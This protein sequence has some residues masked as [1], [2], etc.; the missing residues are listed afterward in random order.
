[1]CGEKAFS[2]QELK[3]SIK[4]IV[5]FDAPMQKHTTFQIGGPARILVIP[6]DIGD[7]Q[8]SILYAKRHGLPIRV[9]GSGSK[10]LVSDK[11]ISGLVI[12]ISSVFDELSIF[13]NT[14]K[15]GAGYNLAK[16]LSIS[17]DHNLSGLEFA[18]GIP[19]T[20]GGAIVMNAG[21][22]LGSISD[23]VNKVNVINLNS[24]SLM[25]FSKEECKFHYRGSI[26]QGSSLF[27]ISAEL[28]LSSGIAIDMRKKIS[29][30]LEKRRESQPLDKP[31]AGSIFKNPEGYSAAKLIDSAGLKGV[32]VGEAQVSDKH[33]NFIVNLGNATAKDVLTLVKLIQ[34]EIKIKYGISLIPELQII[35]E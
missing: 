31:N 1:M 3:G 22:S 28:N 8:K 10:I 16:L 35:S 23:L 26:F 19:G 27:I 12:K 14:L 2:E 29:E 34:T 17:I 25:T 32:R 15:A 6:K 4:G 13:G 9:V 11:G 21:T 7:I 18:A 33:A 30:L 5:L 24:G 20:L